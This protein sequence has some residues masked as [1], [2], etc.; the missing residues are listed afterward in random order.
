[1]WFTTT[2]KLDAF[3]KCF[4]VCAATSATGKT[5]SC[6]E[7]PQKNKSHKKIGR[8][9]QKK[10]SYASPSSKSYLHNEIYLHL[11]K[12]GEHQE[13]NAKFTLKQERI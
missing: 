13:G 4:I 12:R 1:M 9:V 11:K 7:I 6:T 3:G 8:A 5:A 2:E 10:K